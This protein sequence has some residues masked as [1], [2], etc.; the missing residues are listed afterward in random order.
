MRRL[1]ITH[2]IANIS[3]RGTDAPH[4]VIVGKGRNLYPASLFFAAFD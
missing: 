3:G 4:A 1:P 2:W